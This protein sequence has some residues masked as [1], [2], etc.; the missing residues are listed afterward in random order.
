MRGM[1]A[2]NW[3]RRHHAYGLVW[4]KITPLSISH[5]LRNYRV[6]S[7]CFVIFILLIYFWW[8]FLIWFWIHISPMRSQ[9]KFDPT[10]CQ[11]FVGSILIVNHGIVS[12]T[13]NVNPASFLI[14]FLGDYKFTML[15]YL[16][17]TKCIFIQISIIH[18]N[19]SSQV[20]DKRK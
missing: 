5:T 16:S 1:D 7:C 11:D 9:N 15:Q 18:D 14:I 17:L 8:V 20:A 6:H 19:I 4:S 10:F 3:L 13:L 2:F 12:L